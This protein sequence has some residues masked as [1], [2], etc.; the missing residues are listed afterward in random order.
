[1]AEFEGKF[2]LSMLIFHKQSFELFVP[3]KSGAKAI[4]EAT[5]DTQ[6]PNHSADI[7][8]QAH[9]YSGSYGG[10]IQGALAS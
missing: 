3:L 9:Y 4:K 2:A 5:S 6:G 1:M 10:K 7:C 8:P